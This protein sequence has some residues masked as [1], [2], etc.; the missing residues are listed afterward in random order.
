MVSSKRIHPWMPLVFALL[1]AAPAMAVEGVSPGKADDT[2]DAAGADRL[3]E[4]G[5]TL[6]FKGDV[7][8][9]ESVFVTLLSIAPRD[10]RALNNLGNLHLMKG[11]AGIAMAFYARA[12]KADTADAGIPLNRSVALMLSGN[13]AAASA[14]AARAVKMAGGLE[15]AGSLLAV[16][17]G[18]MAESKEAKTP[19][20]TYL[21]KNEVMALLKGAKT[22]VPPSAARTANSAGVAAGETDSLAAGAA[23][24]AGA[25][26][27]PAA[28]PK[29]WRSA[30]LRASD[31][32][33][34][35][36]SL[37]WKM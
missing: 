3:A 14:E 34:I 7:A 27:A 35:A 16:R 1:L 30:G 28:K 10:P 31:F 9:A 11:D 5:V 18:Q 20:R 22:A 32:S 29:S 36:T 4:Y 25:K 8:R 26:S 37:Y 21:S 23:P 17:S 12:E 15:R 33:E 2:H 6:A 13:D 24:G 19:S